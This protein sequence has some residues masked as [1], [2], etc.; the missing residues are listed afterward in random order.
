MSSRMAATVAGFRAQ[1]AFVIQ[2]LA[3]GADGYRRQ[4]VDEQA[5]LCQF[6]RQQ[7]AAGEAQ[8]PIG[9]ERH[10]VGMLLDGANAEEGG[11]A[12]TLHHLL[13]GGCPT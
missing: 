6:P 7:A 12:A 13:K 10:V 1:R 9:A 4:K 3:R 5:A 2:E 8:Q 11:I